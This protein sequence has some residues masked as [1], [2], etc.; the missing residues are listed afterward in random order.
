MRRLIIKRAIYLLGASV[1]I[2]VA[3]AWGQSSDEQGWAL[4]EIIVTAQKRAENQQSVPISVSIASADFM[5][6]NDIRTLE[7]LNGSV[8][9][10]FATNS[11][12]YNTAPVSI[13]GIGGSTGS[14]SFFNDAPVASYVNG[15]YVAR[16]VIP[17]TNL[18]DVDSIQILRGPQGTLYG[19]N[20]TAGAILLTTKRASQE[21][22]AEV[23]GGYARFDEINVGAIVNGAL[24][25]TLSAR[26]VIAYS[27]KPGYGINTNDGSNVNGSQDLTARLSFNF[28]PSDEVSFDLVTEF[29][30]R[31]AQPGLIALSSVEAGNGTADPHVFRP[32]IDQVVEDRE[33]SAL[34][35]NREDS[36]T[37]AV[38]L[39]GEWDLG[40]V[41]IHSV[42]G[43]R[44]LDFHGAQD[45]DNTA[46]EIT[47][48][49][50]PIQAKQFSQE[51]RLESNN[52]GPFSWILGGFYF[53]EDL[54]IQAEVSLFRH[55]GGVGV[56]ASL[57]SSQKT[58]A[59]AV[60]GDGT[61]ELTDR[62]SLTLGW[63]YSYEQKIFN[64]DRID[65]S[66]N[67]GT[68]G[69]G[70]FAGTHEPGD[71][72]RDTP[73]FA[74]KASFKDFSP[75][76]VLDYQV[77]DDVFLFASYSQ[78][79]KSGGFNTFTPAEEF[80]PENI[81]SYEIG[82]KSEWADNRLRLNGS[83]FYNDYT[84]LQ[85]RTSIGGFGASIVNIGVARVQGAE[86][87]MSFAVTEHLTVSGNVA[88]LDAEIT[89][90]FIDARP[91]DAG[92]FTTAGPSGESPQDV[93]GNKLPRSPEWQTYFNVAYE[94]PVGAVMMGLSATYKYQDQVFFL[95]TNQDSEIYNAP[96]WSEIDLRLEISDPD[97]MWE[98]AIYGQN[99]TNKR[100]LSFAAAFGGFPTG[101]Y[102]EPAK[103]GVETVFRF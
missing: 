70:P 12:A 76:A 65:L 29:Y 69:G 19:R 9:G 38:T 34:N 100:R 78:G 83:A 103:W 62:L 42:T 99:I 36:K 58:N 72:M 86:L 54:N 56:E 63:R 64:T 82:F 16:T 49:E 21:F 55:S 13:R 22:E 92:D 77:N 7:D 46:L 81:T 11:V 1:S 6:K 75:R 5:A 37:Y 44:D 74:D 17:T 84:D 79:F 26:G 90:G 68:I 91:T 73:P 27:D 8:P 47:K 80:G 66:I 96:S 24:T 52:D 43:Y 53:S 57:A 2:S 61:Y 30:N 59:V 71:V 98:V 28:T 97:D 50:A 18:Q 85:A 48:N 51:L 45:T 40:A 94:R 87:E 60:F 33:F 23:F 20:S 4:E 67:G 10:F 15:V 31:K 41:S 25:D 3:P 95:E 93:S 14:A 39:L 32:D 102:S 88:Y 89:S 35:A 101:V